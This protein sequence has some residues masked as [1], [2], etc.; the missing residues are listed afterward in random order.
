MFKQLEK[1]N[2]D[3]KKAGFLTFL[4]LFSFVAFFTNIQKAEAVPSVTI[5]E[6]TGPP[7]DIGKVT[8]YNFSQT[9]ISDGNY[10]N[11]IIEVET[12]FDNHQVGSAAGVF[13]PATI[14]GTLNG[15]ARTF[16]VSKVGSKY[17]LTPSVAINL[18]NG[19]NI[20]F[21]NQLRFACKTASGPYTVRIRSGATVLN[22]S[23][24]N[25]DTATGIL[26]I[27]VTPNSFDKAKNDLITYDVKISNN[28][29]ATLY[30]ARAIDTLGSDLQ[31]QSVTPDVGVTTSTVGNVITA[32]V[33]SLAAGTFKKFTVVAK[34]NGCNLV[35]HTITGKWP[36]YGTTLPVCD[37]IGGSSG[38]NS[39]DIAV[40]GVVN[41]VE[42]NPKITYSAP[43]NINLNWGTT[44]TPTTVPVTVS[45]TGAGPANTLY[46]ETNINTSALTIS[47]VT[48]GWSYN[49]AL[50]RFVYS[51]ASLAAGA[52]ANFSYDV[53]AS[54]FCPGPANS[55]VT[56]SGSIT[57][58]PFYT[59]D[60]GTLFSSPLTSSSYLTNSPPVPTLDYQVFINQLLVNINT[61]FSY[62]IRPSMTNVAQLGNP[63]TV[64][65]DVPNAFNMVTATAPI[66]TVV[67]SG[68]GN[69]HV[70]WTFN[71]AS[72]VAG[73][74][75]NVNCFVPND[76]CLANQY[77]VDTTAISGTVPGGG[78]SCGINKTTNEQIFVNDSQ[79]GNNAGI[80]M[81]R[82][83]SSPVKDPIENAYQVCDQIPDATHTAPQY[84]QYLVMENEYIFGN[85]FGA[86]YSTFVFKDPLPV[87][88]GLAG[89]IR[90][91]RYVAGSAEYALDTGAGYG[92]FTPISAG[93]ITYS[94]NNNNPLTINL[95]EVNGGGSANGTKM[96]LRYK[97]YHAY[98]NAA[99][100]N[101]TG[102]LAIFD[103][104]ELTVTRAPNCALYPPTVAKFYRTIEYNV[105]NPRLQLAF[106]GLGTINDCAP[107]YPV[108]LEVRKGSFNVLKN[109]NNITIDIDE[110]TFRINPATITT[111]GFKT[112]GNVNVTPTNSL[113]GNIRTFDFSTN[114]LVSLDDG[115]GKATITF[116]VQKRCGFNGSLTATAKWNNLC[117]DNLT[118]SASYGPTVNKANLAVSVTKAAPPSDITASY[119]IRVTN[120]GQGDALGVDIYHNLGLNLEAT[121]VGT[122]V[123]PAGSSFTLQPTLPIKGTGIGTDLLK[124]TIDKIPSGETLE[125]PL[126]V[127]LVS[128]NGA[129]LQCGGDTVTRTRVEDNCA[130]S[131]ATA[132]LTPPKQVDT[133]ALNVPQ[134]KVTSTIVSPSSVDMCSTASFT[135]KM[136]NRGKTKIYNGKNV[137]TL[138]PELCYVAGSAKIVKIGGNPIPLTSF[139]PS[140]VGQ[141]LTWQY[142][143][144][145]PN[146]AL[147]IFN[148]ISDPANDEVDISFDTKVACVTG[149]NFTI[150]STTS[151]TRPCELDK[152][153][154]TGVGTP[155]GATGV[156]I[157]PPSSA[158]IGVKKPSLSHT[159]PS[160]FVENGGPAKTWT[161]T[162]T[163]SGLAPAKNVG[164][165]I[166]LPSNI[167]LDTGTAAD[168]SPAFSNYNSGTGVITF[169]PGSIPDIAASGGTGIVTLKAKIKDGT[170]CASSTSIGANVTFGCPTSSCV[171][172][173]SLAGGYSASGGV[174]TQPT[175]TSLS[176]SPLTFN[177]CA[178]GSTNPVTLSFKVGD[179]A[180]TPPNDLKAYNVDIIDTL[181][182]GFEFD[183]TVAPVYTGVSGATVAPSTGDTTLNWTLNS[184]VSAGNVSIQFNIRPKATGSCPATNGTNNLTLKY[185]DSCTNSMTDVV[186]NQAV[187]IT[188]P[189]VDYAPTKTNFVYFNAT[190]SNTKII[191]NGQ[192]GINWIISFR[193]TGTAA[194]NGTITSTIGSSFNNISRGT[195]SGGEVPTTPTATTGSWTIAN[196]AAGAT[197]AVSVTADHVG[198]NNT[199]DLTHIATIDGGCATGCK[200]TTT[201]AFDA[202]TALSTTKTAYV[203]LEDLTQKVMYKVTPAAPITNAV[204]GERFKI[205][206][207][208]TFSG[209]GSNGYTNVVI[210]DTLPK[211]GVNPLIKI[212]SNPVPIVYK[213]EPTD[214]VPVV[215]T[216]NWT[217]VPASAGNSWVASWTRNAAPAFVTPSEITIEYEA[218]I[219][220]VTPS[221]TGMSSAIATNIPKSG[222]VLTNANDTTYDFGGNSYATN[223]TATVTVNEPFLTKAKA[224][225]NLT[226]GTD[227]VQT[228]NTATRGTS[229]NTLVGGTEKV[230]Y[231]ITLT[232]TGNAVAHDVSVKDIVPLGMRVATPSFAPLTGAKLNGTDVPLGQITTSY[233]SAT[234]LYKIQF[235]K[236]NGFIGIPAGQ[237]LV[238]K[239]YT[240]V[241]TNVSANL[242]MTNSMTIMNNSPF[243]TRG[244]EGYSSLPSDDPDVALN[245]DRLY[246]DNTPATQTVKTPLSPVKITKT[247]TTEV[248]ETGNTTNTQATP[249]EMVTYTIAMSTQD[250]GTGSTGFNLLV[251][252]LGPTTGAL[253]TFT[254]IIPDGLEVDQGRSS[255]AVTSGTTSVVPTLSYAVSA[256]NGKTTITSNSFDIYSNSVVTATIVTRVKEKYVSGGAPVVAKG[257]VLVNGGNNTA[258]A[259][260]STT[261][262]DL[263]WQTTSGS[264]TD[265]YSSTV[266]TTVVEPTVTANKI[267]TSAASTVSPG[268]IVSYRIT[269]TNSNAANTSVAHNVTLTDV[270]PEGMR[271]GF[272]P[273]TDSS[274]S[275]PATSKTYD[276]ALGKITWVFANLNPNTTVTINYNVKV[277]PNLSV[278]VSGTG[279]C[280]QLINEAR[281]NSYT[282]FDQIDTSLKDD[283]NLPL[284]LH[285]E[286]K[287][288]SPTASFPVPVSV[289]GITLNPVHNVTGTPGSVVVMP[290]TIVSCS[291]AP[292][293]L[294]TPT[295][296]KGWPVAIYQD[297]SP[298]HDGS[299]LSATPITSITP[300]SPGAPVYIAIKEQIPQNAPSSVLDTLVLNISQTVPGVATP[301]TASVIDTVSTS[302]NPNQPNGGAGTGTLKLVKSVDKTTAN[303]GEIVTYT[304]DYTNTGT[305]DLMGI[306]I[307]DVTPEGTVLANPLPSFVTG[308]GSVTHPGLNNKGVITWTVTGN[309]KAGDKG[310]I[311]FSVKIE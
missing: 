13:P 193:N 210:R 122:V 131:G 251:S 245:L 200:H 132:C 263:R 254:D 217:Y 16:N 98:V 234:G 72:F 49:S 299:V 269:A 38:Q 28:G 270:L 259:N 195:G 63:V 176:I 124:W 23:F 42:K 185:K 221:S 202:D 253:N 214:T 206:L 129:A 142:G 155:A 175:V 66:G 180:L 120:S 296:Q 309:L 75:L 130:F 261:T 172:Q 220:D 162:L 121:S 171:G 248:T 188:K 278:K 6:V 267:K 106:T 228:I 91:M 22:S 43:A 44:A 236:A 160:Q 190:N 241:D 80:E 19:D 165:T 126:I 205:Q 256:V 288:Y 285:R 164:A 25:I 181:P 127:T 179:T 138:P 198:A 143:T 304:I 184:P 12:A 274:E 286:R 257:N 252:A 100:N 15:A 90:D 47:N 41:I 141:T 105:K 96:K 239:Y 20:T 149:A 86:N 310:Q 279:T 69:R 73:M 260:S 186:N 11:A 290:H 233:T 196:L 84:N 135:V 273:N 161:L 56:T 240:T 78:A 7:Y 289:V 114:D 30:N 311:K 249:G 29:L 237:S 247:V 218:Y 103:T 55:P 224:Q 10:P 277:D 151:Y 262:T 4:F 203:S 169:N 153:G 133:P 301:L 45:N 223:G 183:G 215:D 213:K 244:D 187:T 281:L 125:I 216:A 14:S 128:N 265:L 246:G 97:I 109:L 118:V 9:I 8:P 272:D 37:D 156:T 3:L 113:T 230:G 74:E 163:N 232:N 225:A 17:T 123:M 208:S 110:S 99:P 194:F 152:F 294:T 231:Q 39:N 51:G 211:N 148:S 255:I 52:N 201:A 95:L 268:D 204:V 250:T 83:I 145:A 71:P 117:K 271:I 226:V 166:T 107:E 1:V 227:G 207:K 238:I 146:N 243:A 192:T 158:V 177:T 119:T 300:S 303:P 104:S 2:L 287:I 197:W 219:N 18:I 111:N 139:E 57:Y 102:N 136:I 101:G 76:P 159:F 92:A 191:T 209:N 298:N 222:D 284:N 59:S 112:Y 282:N 67:T 302:L 53:K 157:A 48:N 167:V 229:P 295:S 87:S 24:K 178:S 35:D 283:V 182:A 62:L 77:H 199:T 85:T 82:T 168:T 64:T 147:N 150:S 70:V 27:V 46:I 93:N 5:T 275:I 276:Q 293:T 26:N 34:V 58:L 40:D 88:N 297:L 306:E 81:N 54:Q 79:P 173:C 305:D 89:G 174:V 33:N 189:V 61:N 65:F 144:T 242:S 94:D 154:P 212:H 36:A 258:S 170:S 60:C 235:L 140:V 134:S 308:T 292:I 115:T 266:S 31:I 291:N 116:N 280:L 307:E 21:S 137:V 264:A 50:N 32:D 68:V 108:T